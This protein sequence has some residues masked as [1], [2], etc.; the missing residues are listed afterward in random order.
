M[1]SPS[2]DECLK[3]FEGFFAESDRN[4]YETLKGLR[5]LKKQVESS[6]RLIENEIQDETEIQE[7]E[8]S[9]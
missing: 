8:C 4:P 7:V 2:L 5:L 3:A 6:I 9:G 1:N